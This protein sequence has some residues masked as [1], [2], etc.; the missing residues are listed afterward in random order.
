MDK[1]QRQPKGLLGKFLAQLESGEEKTTREWSEELGVSEVF[2]R[3]M[4]TKL[5]QTY[6]YHQYHPVESKR[7]HNGKQGVITDIYKKKE[8][9]VSTMDHSKKI[10]IDPQLNSFSHWLQNGYRKYP[11]LRQNF[12]AFLSDEISK[13]ALLDENL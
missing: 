1:T 6:G 3:T 13:L 4:L 5:R 7:G 8:W 10:A 11:E 9:V 2:I 12:K